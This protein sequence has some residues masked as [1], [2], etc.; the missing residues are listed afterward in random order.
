MY[1][2]DAYDFNNQY[3]Y[4]DKDWKS[5]IM[6]LPLILALSYIFSLSIINNLN[7]IINTTIFHA[8]WNTE[9]FTLLPMSANLNSLPSLN[10]IIGSSVEV[11]TILLR[12]T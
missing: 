10:P 9:T 1:T 6:R 2:L 7:P 12:S 5:V 4:P 8:I 11:L 3:Q